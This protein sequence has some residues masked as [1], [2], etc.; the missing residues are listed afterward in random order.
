MDA[1]AKCAA[2]ASLG[3][4][5]TSSC[6]RTQT[7]RPASAFARSR[8]R[9]RASGQIGTHPS[10]RASRATT[11]RS[12]RSPIRGAAE[13]LIGTEPWGPGVL[14][15]SAIASHAARG[16]NERPTGRPRTVA[17]EVTSGRM[18]LAASA[19]ESTTPCASRNRVPCLTRCESEV[20]VPP[21]G[22]CSANA[23]KIVVSLAA[24]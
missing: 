19:A 24:P 5:P 7:W 1:L 13:T 22:D 8:N 21:S 16:C 4:G 23:S 14:N 11:V 3:T 20:R 17:E 18:T 15:R 2:T 6:A 9:E 12:V 10:V